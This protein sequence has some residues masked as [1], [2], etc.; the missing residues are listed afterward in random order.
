M[1]GVFVCG[2]TP[3]Y[4]HTHTHTHTHAVIKFVAKWAEGDPYVVAG[5]FNLNPNSPQYKL[6]TKGE[7]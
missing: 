7:P 4:K 5:D 3:P 1:R 6:I 2:H